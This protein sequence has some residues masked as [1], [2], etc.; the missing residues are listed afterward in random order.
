[1]NDKKS[2]RRFIYPIS[3]QV[4]N[5]AIVCL[6]VC[7]FVFCFCFFFHEKKY[8]PYEQCIYIHSTKIEI[9]IF[10]YTLWTTSLKYTSRCIFQILVKLHKLHLI[11]CL[12]DKYFWFIT[13]RIISWPIAFLEHNILILAIKNNDK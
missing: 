11:L 3:E 9:K 13:T 4:G 7:L 2:F 10:M 1:M 8:L 5:S 12:T 6:V